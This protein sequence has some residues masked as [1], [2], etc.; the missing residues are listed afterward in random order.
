MFYA[1][2]VGE[3]A[4]DVGCLHFRMLIFFNWLANNQFL[5]TVAGSLLFLPL[6]QLLAVK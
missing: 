6:G 1:C 5:M 2:N 4:R 3:H